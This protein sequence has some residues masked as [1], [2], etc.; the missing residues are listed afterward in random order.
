MQAVLLAGGQ[1]RE[2]LV[3]LRSDLAW[4][5]RPL[6]LVALLASTLTALFVTTPVLVAAD[7]LGLFRHCC[8]PFGDLHTNENGP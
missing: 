8:S 4:G 3:R 5:R 1:K 7:Y 6:P 2:P